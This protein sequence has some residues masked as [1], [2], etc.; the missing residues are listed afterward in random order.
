MGELLENR[1]QGPK[2]AASGPLPLPFNNVRMRHDESRIAPDLE[3]KSAFVQCKNARC[4]FAC[5]LALQ[6]IGRLRKRNGRGIRHD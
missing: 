3:M 1:K 2:T 4:V 6:R 5:H